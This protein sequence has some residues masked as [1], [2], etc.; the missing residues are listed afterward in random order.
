MLLNVQLPAEYKT[1]HPVFPVSLT[2]LHKQ[3]PE[4]FGSRRNYDIAPPPVE[5]N[6]EGD[7]EWEIDFIRKER[8][9]RTNDGP[10]KEY[11]VHW[12]GWDVSWDSWEP[13]D[14][15]NAPDALAEFQRS[16]SK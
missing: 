10:V 7:A 8:T 2:E 1:R 12:K 13:Q 16:K 9:R 6:P 11:L 4:E 14:N 3:N 5:V 15:L